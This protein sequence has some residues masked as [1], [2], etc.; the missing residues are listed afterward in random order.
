[1]WTI[2]AIT[3]KVYT[4]YSVQSYADIILHKRKYISFEELKFVYYSL[5]IYVYS[6]ETAVEIHP[7][8][9]EI[10]SCKQWVTFA[11]LKTLKINKTNELKRCTLFDKITKICR[12]TDISYRKWRNILFWE[13]RLQSRKAMIYVNRCLISVGVLLAAH[14]C[15]RLFTCLSAL[16][17]QQ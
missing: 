8:S 9:D 6:L 10:Y 13:S 14:R 11:A 7:H 1:M 5:L 16:L 3:E 12:S 17:G 15:L 2:T 4:S